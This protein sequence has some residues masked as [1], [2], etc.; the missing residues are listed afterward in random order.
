MPDDRRAGHEGEALL[1]RLA[2]GAFDWFTANRHPRTGLVRDRAGNR[3][4]KGTR[5]AMA[6]VAATGY[7]LSLL[8]E[9][10]PRD[11]IGRRDAEAE[12]GWVLRFVSDRLEQ[13][14]GLL[15]HFVH[16]ETGARWQKSEMSALDTAIF[17]NGCL[18]L[19][20][21]FPALADAAN[22]LV[23]RV[24]WR[25]YLTKHARTG[26]PLLAFGW[27]PEQGLLGPMWERSSEMAMPYFLAAGSAGHAI[28][29]QCW[30][31]TDVVR[32]EVCGHTV[33]NPEHPLFTSYYGL[34]W[35]RLEGMPDRDG[36]DFHANARAAALANRAFCR[37]V[38]AKKYATY[39]ETVGGWWGISAGDGPSGYV[40]PGPVLAAI[41]GTVWPTASAAAVAWAPWEVAEDV[42]RWRASA[43]WERAAGPGGLG[44]FNFD[45]NW[46]GEDL[47][48]IDLG[49]FFLNWTNH[50]HGTVWDLWMRHPVAQA[51]LRRLGYK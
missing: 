2:R 24:D 6:S 43:A 18:V 15:Y 30:Y 31:N 47:L 45:K 10:V 46:F 3:P 19:A 27:S 37:T 12:A 14:H 21:A 16:W 40:A 13:R 9:A 41:D 17:L 33:L 44:P 35:A 34:G 48:G 32:G 26:R 50:R 11:W 23:E 22:R 28:D 36:V 49:S 5:S 29:P 38:A 4:G 20:V 39:R 1:D 7:Y 8:P 25:A 51:A 42:A